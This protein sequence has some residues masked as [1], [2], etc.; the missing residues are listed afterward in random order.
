LSVDLTR[1]VLIRAGTVQLNLRDVRRAVGGG[2][3]NVLYHV[4]TY[5]GR[6]DIP[7]SAFRPQIT[8]ISAL[9]YVSPGEV[10]ELLL[11]GKLSPNMAFF[12]LTHARALLALAPA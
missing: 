9:R 3:L 10:D 1:S 11:S 6:T 5:L 12:W 7:A 2:V 8:E 4:S